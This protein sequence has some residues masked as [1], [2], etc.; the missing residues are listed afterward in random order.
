[1]K[2]PTRKIAFAA[3]LAVVLAAPARAEDV[4]AGDLV[5]TQAWSRRRRRAR[6]SRAVTSPSRTRA[7]ADRLIAGAPM[8]QAA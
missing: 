7:P 2:Q 1:M 5:I 3:A 8:S 4:K 6:R